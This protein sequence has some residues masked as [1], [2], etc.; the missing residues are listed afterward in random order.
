MKQTGTNCEQ[1]KLPEWA[2]MSLAL[3]FVA[4][5]FAACS[6]VPF[7]LGHTLGVWF[8]LLGAS[9]AVVCWVY[10]VRPMPGFMAGIIAILGLCALS[11][12][13]I[14]WIIRVVRYVAF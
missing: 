11:G 1:S 3:A 9:V 10:L 14:A 13:L 8:G 5:L 12:L 7:V 6:G 4:L 2:R